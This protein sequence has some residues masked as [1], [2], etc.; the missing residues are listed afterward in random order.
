M[1]S[2]MK[3]TLPEKLEKL[4]LRVLPVTYVSG[5]QTVSGSL[6]MLV[7]ADANVVW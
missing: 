7:V 6:S 1:R 4:K 5:C 3:K 2:S